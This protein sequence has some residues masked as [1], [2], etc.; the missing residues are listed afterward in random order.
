MQL[1]YIQCV[2]FRS[3]QFIQNFS[4]DPNQCQIRAIYDA[5][6]YSYKFSTDCNLEL[7]DNKAKTDNVII[8][9]WPKTSSRTDQKIAFLHFVE[10]VGGHIIEHKHPEQSTPTYI[11]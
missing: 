8:M 7:M 6:V 10:G 9:K 1:S 3:I 5:E 11:E 2:Q 4:P